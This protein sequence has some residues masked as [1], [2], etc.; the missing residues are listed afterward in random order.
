MLTQYLLVVHVGF[1]RKF[2]EIVTLKELQKYAKPGG[3]LEN[4]QTLKMSR[5]SVSRVSK[6][7]W[8]F[9]HTLMET[10]DGAAAAAHQPNMTA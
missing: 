3:V 7:E 1:R 6:K 4:M 8:E 5:L 9:I 2:P 10:D